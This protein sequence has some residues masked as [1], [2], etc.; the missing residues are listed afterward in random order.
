MDFS[1][2]VLLLLL[3]VSVE[4]VVSPLPNRVERASVA[5]IDSV[6]QRVSNGLRGMQMTL[7]VPNLIS[8]TTARRSLGQL[9]RNLY[10]VESI[11]ERNN[12][13]LDL[14]NQLNRI[15]REIE[16]RIT[17][18]SVENQSEVFEE[19]QRLPRVLDTRNRR[20][21]PPVMDINRDRLEHYLD[22]GLS[23]RYIARNSER[24]LGGSVHHNTIH[25][26][27]QRNSIV[28][29]RNRFT[30]MADRDLERT[31]RRLNRQYPNS[32]AQEMVSLL[33]A[34]T[35]SVIVQRDRCRRI[36]STVDPIGTARRWAQAIRRRQYSVPTPN[37]YW[38]LDSNH[39]LI[40]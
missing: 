13:F 20:Y 18:L 40:R 2:A 22:I 10:R 15:S 38:H 39:G 5:T 24:L 21:G 37:W 30:T 27:M 32:G 17:A 11:V 26:F 16:A 6:L 28:S 3:F 12:E 31:V 14:E 23:V 1:V 9:R 4:I 35:P 36:L 34:Q 19:P 33:R 8:L 7:S 25:R 29:H